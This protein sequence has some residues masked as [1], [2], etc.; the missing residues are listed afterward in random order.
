MS[1][2]FD[3][4]VERQK[5][6]SI[7]WGAPH[8]NLQPDEVAAHPLPMWVADMDFK[9][10]PAVIE[11]LERAV[12]DGIFGYPFR[13]A[14]YEEAVCG[15]QNRR[16]GWQPKPEWL[17]QT[18]GVIT[19]LSMIIQTFTREGD[20]VLIQPPVYG[21]FFNDVQQNNRRV[22]EAPLTLNGTS[23][24]FDPD[25][26]ESSITPETRLFILCNP[27]N[28]TGNVWSADDLRRMGE[29]CLRHKILVV[30]DE[31][32]Q[33]LIF[34]P[35]AKHIPF[36]SL[37]DE[38]AKNAIVCTAPSKSFN[39][40]G[41]Q[42]SN[43]FAADDK[44]RSQLQATLVRGG[45][46]FVN[47]LGAVACEAAYSQGEDW[48]EHLL[49]YIRGNHQHFASSIHQLFP[50]LRVLNTDALYLAWMDCR[51]MNMAAPELEKFM[52][53]QGRVWFDRGSKFGWQGQGFM[54][55]NL[56][57]PRSTVD[58]AINRLKNALQ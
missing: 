46:N 12:R 34:N 21:H 44:I 23:Y 56:G 43:L 20:A 8:K 54:R 52:L 57:C 31:I 13:T 1:D 26:F 2:Y 53:T 6:N 10:P 55:V 5:S 36:A 38:F 3:R 37:G 50:Q 35:H 49:R 41:L 14:S 28:P 32:H 42:C 33:D 29:I 45:L 11:A 4:V 27:H 39:L 48:L 18:P 9:S 7:K 15:W 22:N 16:F 19:A 47:A 25:A 30:S 58:E 51:G 24:S 40:A 17:V